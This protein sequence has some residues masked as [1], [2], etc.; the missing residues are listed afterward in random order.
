MVM[1]FLERY[2]ANFEEKE[3]VAGIFG[4]IKTKLTWSES[5]RVL[6]WF[7][8]KGKIEQLFHQLNLVTYWQNPTSKPDT[9]LHPYRSSEVYLTNGEKLGIFGQIHPILANQLA[10]SSQIYLFEF[11]LEVIK[12]QLQKNK[13]VLYKEYSLYPKIVKD[14]SFIIRQDIPFEKLQEALYCNG[15]KFLSDI[16]LLDEYRGKSIPKGSTSLCLQFIF[17]SKEKTLETKEIESIMNHLQ[18]ILTNQFDVLIRN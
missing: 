13:L 17:Q 11:D 1:F 16:N 6:S 9:I 8:A 10:I 18:F 2:G 3:Y 14:L 5:E 7:E 4:G 15:T 12:D